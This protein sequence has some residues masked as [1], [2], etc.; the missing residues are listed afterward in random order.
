M[1]A[2]WLRLVPYGLT[3]TLGFVTGAACVYLVVREDVLNFP[4]GIANNILFLVLFFRASLFGDSA[5]QI[6]YMALGIQGWYL[7]MRGGRNHTNL[8]ITR[9]P[10][11]T[12]L[13]LLLILLVGTG[14]LAVLLWSI[15]GAVPLLD[16][17][18]T[19]LS[20]IAQ[21]M[22]NKKYLENWFVWMVADVL[23][24][25]MYFSRQL[26]LTAIL[27]FAFLLLCIAGARRWWRTI[28]LRTQRET[29]N[30]FATS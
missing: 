12:L 7:W 1:A 13:W 28:R 10:T 30:E 4:V 8:K 9:T 29:S 3:E 5:L 18:T 21:Y 24:V 19:V 14:V 25:Y 15:K 22:L 2:S 17:L 26:S 23:Y 27:Y 11:K 6:V 16:A 20:L